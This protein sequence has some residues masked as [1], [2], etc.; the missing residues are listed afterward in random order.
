MKEDFVSYEL[1]VKLK[2]K[3]FSEKCLY[4]Y[5][6]NKLVSNTCKSDNDN[7]TTEDLLMSCNYLVSQF[8]TVGSN[9][10]VSD[11]PTIP[12]VLKWLREEKKIYVALDFFRF[13]G[14]T[15]LWWTYSVRYIEDDSTEN[16]LES[17]KRESWEQAAL[18][19]IE[20]VID[21]LI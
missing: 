13:N 16:I 2:E 18:A 6:D 12:Q 21:N 19:G 20:Y 8:D 10:V 1:A 7:I 3:G 14:N 9:V 11:A 17:C 4:H 5:S 15:E